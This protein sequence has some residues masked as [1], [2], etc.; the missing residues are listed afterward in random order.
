[1]VGRSQFNFLGLHRAFHDYPAQ[2]SVYHQRIARSWHT[3]ARDRAPGPVAR[4]LESTRPVLGC[5]V[6]IAQRGASPGGTNK[7]KCGIRKRPS[8]LLL[9]TVQGARDWL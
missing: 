5:G 4:P 9:H 6:H 7:I 8:I 3:V 1:M 2:S